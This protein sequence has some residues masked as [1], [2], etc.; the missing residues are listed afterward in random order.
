MLREEK[1]EM[2][3]NVFEKG[4]FSKYK[5]AITLAEAQGPISSLSDRN[6][7]I[8]VFISHKHD[9]LNELEGI[10]NMLRTIYK[11]YPYIDSQDPTLPIKTS[12]ITAQRIRERIEQCDRFVMLAR[13]GAIESKWCNW[14]LGFGDAKK[15]KEGRIAL[16]PIKSKGVEDFEYKGNEYMKLYPSICYRDKNE[17]YSDGSYFEEGYYV[18]TY[19]EDTNSWE[20]EPLERWLMK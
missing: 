18:R 16:W 12:A 19:K 13:E 20:V 7:K 4:Y 10:L 6:G 3:I 17:K 11:V 2:K 15:W 5:G 8:A 9:D 1:K 14:E